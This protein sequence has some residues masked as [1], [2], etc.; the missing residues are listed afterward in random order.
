MGTTTICLKDFFMKKRIGTILIVVAV[1]FFLN[2]IFGRY[3]V[4]PGYL[5][6]LE[7]GRANLA[8]AGQ[9]VDGWKVARYL[10][11]AYSFKLGLL[12]LTVGAFL[13]TTMKPARFWL[14]TVAGFVYV[15]FAYVPLPAPVSTVFGVAG[16]IMTILM[17]SI[18]LSWA[19]ERVQLP[20]APGSA[21]DFR[22]AGYFF[23]AMATY[24]LCPLMGIKTFALQPEKM[25]EY[26]LQGEAASFAFHVL[27]ELVLGWLF[28][29]IGYKKEKPLSVIQSSGKYIPA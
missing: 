6:S 27:I 16:G 24:T 14:F 13:W 5:E 17:I 10:L 4:L 23:F 7:A 15:G 18:V 25:I 22:M 21:S 28:T 8:A 1:L 12:F 9:S 3:I 19:R 29:F 11:W 20:E 26:G 2:A